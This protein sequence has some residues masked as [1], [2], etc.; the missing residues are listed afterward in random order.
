MC[1]F[2]SLQFSY[3]SL[4]VGLFLFTDIFISFL[5]LHPPNIGL[6][7][8]AAV[9]Y[10][11]LGFFL[12]ANLCTGLVNFSMDTLNANWVVGLTVLCAYMV[13]LTLVFCVLLKLN[14]KIKL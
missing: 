11:Q 3:G 4:I 1:I 7:I 2:I 12:L 5:S 6:S 9:D 14:I 10:N 8:V 13:V